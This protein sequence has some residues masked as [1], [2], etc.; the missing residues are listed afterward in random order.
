MT[1]FVNNNAIFFETSMISFFANKSFHS[2]IFFSLDNIVYT[3]CY[4]STSHEGIR[5]SYAI[6]EICRRLQAMQAITWQQGIATL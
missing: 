2:H 1:K 5:E 6:E 3:I 4:A